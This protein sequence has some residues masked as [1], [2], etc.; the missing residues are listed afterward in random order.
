MSVKLYQIVPQHKSSS[1]LQQRHINEREEVLRIIDLILRSIQSLVFLI[2]E[3]VNQQRLHI[4]LLTFCC[5]Y[6]VYNSLV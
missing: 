4:L 3:N 1:K 2:S 6:H 5:V